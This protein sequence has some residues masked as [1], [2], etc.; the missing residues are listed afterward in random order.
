MVTPF[1]F[2]AGG[3]IG[4]GRQFMP[5]IHLHDL[6]ELLVTAMEDERCRGAA[7]AAAPNPIRN[8]DFARALGQALG[9]ATT[10]PSNLV[11]ISPLSSA[12]FQNIG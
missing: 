10:R 11:N 2:Y 6:A 12:R 4:S 7:I 5:W 8:R 1:Q 3:P 9:R